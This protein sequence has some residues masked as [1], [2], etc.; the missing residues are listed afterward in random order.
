MSVL[1]TLNLCDDEA[2]VIYQL[3]YSYLHFKAWFPDWWN[4]GKNILFAFKV[5]G[6]ISMWDLNKAN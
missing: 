1:K 3:S 6:S 4:G 2:W 5:K